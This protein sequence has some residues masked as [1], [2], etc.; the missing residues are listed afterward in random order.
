[1]HVYFFTFSVSDGKDPRESSGSG[2]KL[3]DTKNNKSKNIGLFIGL[4]LGLVI[5]LVIGLLVGYLIYN[6]KK[7][8]VYN[9]PNAGRNGLPCICCFFVPRCVQS[10]GVCIVFSCSQSVGAPD[11]P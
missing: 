6:K 5:A 7:N 1:M 10:V 3:L 11:N 8:R 2:G 9:D 4:S